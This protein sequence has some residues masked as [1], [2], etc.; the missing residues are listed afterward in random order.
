MYE[1]LVLCSF[2]N[3]GRINRQPDDF[4][5]WFYVFIPQRLLGLEPG[6]Q[7]VLFETR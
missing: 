4:L 2:E 7:G 5:W 3:T 1:M 6:N